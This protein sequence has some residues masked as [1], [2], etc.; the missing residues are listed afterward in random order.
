M[1]KFTPAEVANLQ[2]GGN[3]VHRIH[4]WLQWGLLHLD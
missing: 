4:L 1:A 2:A 3:G